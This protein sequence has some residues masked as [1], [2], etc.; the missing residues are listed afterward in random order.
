MYWI[1]HIM[2]YS[3]TSVDV[4]TSLPG[5]SY[6]FVYYITCCVAG[7]N[8][9]SMSYYFLSIDLMIYLTWQQK[10]NIHYKRIPVSLGT[11]YVDYLNEER[12]MN[13]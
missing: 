11:L 1:F 13:A 6:N 8:K 3:D 7:Y 4:V 12:K 5:C 10:S 2:K 9:F